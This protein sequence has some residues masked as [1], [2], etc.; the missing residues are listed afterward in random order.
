MIIPSVVII[1]LSLIFLLFSL[2]IISMSFRR[3]VVTW[4]PAI[5]VA[6]G[7]VLIAVDIARTGKNRGGG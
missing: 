3:F 4:W 7:M 2:R 1:V 6:A 5:L